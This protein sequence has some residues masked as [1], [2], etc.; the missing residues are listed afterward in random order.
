MFYYANDF[1][2]RCQKL[3]RR[4]NQMPPPAM[5]CIFKRGK[6]LSMAFDID[7]FASFCFIYSSLHK[8]KL[9]TKENTMITFHSE[10]FLNV[11]VNVL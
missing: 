5:F 9:E 10:Y 11:Q 7:H 8:I 1:T 4:G 6:I 2:G 3:G